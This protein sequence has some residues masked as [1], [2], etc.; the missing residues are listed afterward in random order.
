MINSQQNL[1]PNANRA[2]ISQPEVVV[3]VM[4][5]FGGPEKITQRLCALIRDRW[6]K[7]EPGLPE[8][9]FKRMSPEGK[10]LIER[11]LQGED[12]PVPFAG[13]MDPLCDPLDIGVN[14]YLVYEP[15][16]VSPKKLAEIRAHEDCQFHSIHGTRADGTGAASPNLPDIGDS[17]LLPAAV[18]DYDHWISMRRVG[19]VPIPVLVEVGGDGKS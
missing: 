6:A 11:V 14:Q 15:K 4:D 18:R 5:V 12:I 3:S 9:L 8:L 19:D 2:G 13:V 7:L 10:A 17:R 1:H 16:A